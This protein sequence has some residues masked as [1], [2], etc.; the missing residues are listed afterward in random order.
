MSFAKPVAALDP[1]N[2][3]ADWRGEWEIKEDSQLLPQA[4]H[5]IG[6][7]FY[8]EFEQID[9]HGNWGWVV[10]DDVVSASRM[11][12]LQTEMSHEDFSTLRQVLY[13]QA[14]LR[15]HELGYSDWSIRADP[16]NKA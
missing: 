12:E 10:G 1:A 8:F 9:E 3:S 2:W 11:D 4:W 6:L 7:C 5:R 16:P 14:K 13:R 15:W